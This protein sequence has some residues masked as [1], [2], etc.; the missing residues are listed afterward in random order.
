LQWGTNIAIY[1]ER[2]HSYPERL[3]NL[4]FTFLFV[5]RAATKVSAYSHP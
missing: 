1:K 5:L 4:Y 2:I 3:Q